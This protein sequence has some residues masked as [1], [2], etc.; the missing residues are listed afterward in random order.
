MDMSTRILLVEDN[1]GDARIVREMLRESPS[2]EEITVVERIRDCIRLIDDQLVDLIL[3]DLSLPDSS[4]LNGFHRLRAHSSEIPIII[5]TGFADIRIAEEAVRSGAHDYLVKGELE[6]NLLLHA[7]QYSVLRHAFR[8]DLEELSL[9]DPLTSLY[10]RRGFRLLA[11][12]SLRLAK[13][14][15]RE[16]VLLI[17]DM[18]DLK[19]INDT[20]GH[21]AGDLALQAAARSFTPALRDSDIVAR[22]GGDEFVALAVEAQPPGISSLLERVDTQLEMENQKL[23]MA[24]PLSLSIGA[25]PFDPSESPSLNDLIV[26]ADRDM[27]EKK[28]AYRAQKRES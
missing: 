10:N 22:L 9:R 21:A 7:V 1:P 3:L 13:R 15:A 25:T 12:Q 27:Y 4:G 11:E 28:E 14:N 5:L 8:S 20:Y 2:I 19:E 24:L 16:S 23:N 6:G 26:A 18:N 17:A